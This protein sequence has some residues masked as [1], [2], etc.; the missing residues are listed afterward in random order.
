MWA[1]SPTRRLSA[2]AYRGGPRSC[3]IGRPEGR[4]GPTGLPQKVVESRQA[5]R[6]QCASHRA[7]VA[8]RGGLMSI[9]FLSLLLRHGGAV[10]AVV[11]ATGVG[12]VLE[13]LLAERTLFFCYFPAVV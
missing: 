9:S 6:K 13:P 3:P 10:V 12:L 5:P 4:A 2:P 1:A 8:P 7:D 11:V